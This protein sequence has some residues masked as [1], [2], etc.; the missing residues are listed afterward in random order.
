V[1]DY[2]SASILKNKNIPNLTSMNSNVSTS[3][4]SISG[5]TTVGTLPTASVLIA[6]SF[7]VIKDRLYTFGG[8]RTTTG[9]G[10]N[11]LWYTKINS[12][13][14]INFN[15]IK[16]DATFPVEMGYHADHAIIGNNIYFLVGDTVSQTKSFL[17]IAKIESDG[18]IK[19]IEIE[20]EINIYR[21][22]PG[23]C[24]CG[25]K[26]YI[27]GGYDFN[28]N[29][30]KN[31]MYFNINSDYTLSE[32]MEILVD[33]LP[34]NFTQSKNIINTGKKLYLLGYFIDG[35][36]SNKVYSATINNDGSISKFTLDSIS[37]PS[38]MAYFSVIK[39]KNKLFTFGSANAS[40]QVNSIYMADI[41]SN[42]VLGSF[43][44]INSFISMH[45]CSVIVCGNYGYIMGGAIKVLLLS[46]FFDIP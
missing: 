12:D 35:A 6:P 14:S 16:E 5:F 28:A 41:D 26:L 8:Y 43:T 44:A 20:R 29:T 33:Y 46:A 7:F 13:N 19:S 38:N 18:S 40:G 34:G 27:I 24:V 31:I 32:N 45:F 15:W 42:G 4:S 25:D 37:F 17:L 9:Y 39:Y 30:K 36:Y 23:L 10:S 1:V 22:N 21:D 2:Y 11:Q 3:Q